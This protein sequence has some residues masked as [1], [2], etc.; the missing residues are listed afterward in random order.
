MLKTARES[1][2]DRLTALC[3]GDTKSAHQIETQLYKKIVTPNTCLPWD[4]L[5]QLKKYNLA[6]YLIFYDFNSTNCLSE[7]LAKAKQ[8]IEQDRIGWNHDFF[9]NIRKDVHEIREWIKNPI[10]IEEGIVTCKRC[11]SKRVFSYQK[12]TRSCDEPSTTFN[13]CVKCGDKWTYSG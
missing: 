3:E 10:E 7:A 5:K 12:Q 13:E 8:N 11:K 4:K 6:S 9:K 2:L 1:T